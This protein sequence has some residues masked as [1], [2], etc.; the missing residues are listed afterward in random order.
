MN[1]S[2]INRDK[3]TLTYK[4]YL[5]EKYRPLVF[6]VR[7][8]EKTIGK[9]KAL[10]MVENTFYN[11]MCNLVKE[12][13]EELGPVNE[14]TDFARIE[15]EENELIEFRNTVTIRYVK[16]TE[17]ELGLHI[18]ECLEAEVFKELEAEDIGYLVVCNPDYA[19]A[20]ACNPCVK[21]RRNKTLME[22]DDYCDHLWYWD[23]SENPT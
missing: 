4:E 22:G 2:I 21:L 3:I 18:T 11:D 6:F 14:F 16:D 12:K 1:E 20:R 15:K 23:N 8:M 9:V 5:T 19:Y 10:E 13:L 7:E 17:S